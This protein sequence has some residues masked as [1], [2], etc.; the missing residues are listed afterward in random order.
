MAEKQKKANL[1]KK[2]TRKYTRISQTAII[3]QIELIGPYPA[4]IAEKLGCHYNTIHDRTLKDDPDYSPAVVAAFQ[5]AKQKRLEIA[6]NRLFDNNYPEG[7]NPTAD[8][9]VHKASP[10]AKEAGWGERTVL[11][12]DGEAPLRVQL[13]EAAKLLDKKEK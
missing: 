3:E 7:Q 8:I 12:G 13:L 9:F 1:Y 11:A 5:N 2:Y 4:L 10:E 6:Q